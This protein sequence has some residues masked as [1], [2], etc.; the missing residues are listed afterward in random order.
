VQ[1][2]IEGDKFLKEVKCTFEG[3]WTTF[4]TTGA[5]LVCDVQGKVARHKKMEEEHGKCT[6]AFLQL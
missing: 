3:S 2:C 5:K 6:K 1:I 4:S